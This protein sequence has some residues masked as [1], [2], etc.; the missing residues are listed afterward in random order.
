[1]PRFL[2]ALLAT[3]IAAGAAASESPPLEPIVFESA[4]SPGAASGILGLG[5]S[6]QFWPGH[7]FY[8]DSPVRVSG[9][10]GGITNAESS[11]LT[12]FAALVSLSGPQDFPDAL[13]LDAGDLVATSLVDLPAGISADVTVPLEADLE[14]G[15]YALVFGF[16]AFGA[17]NKPDNPGVSLHSHLVDTQPDQSAFVAVQTFLGGEGLFHRSPP[18]TLIRTFVRGRVVPEA[19]SGVMA[20]LG[21][22]FVCCKRRMPRP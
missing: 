11:S 15:W 9:V 1:M 22:G 16:D 13:D 14:P 4:R 6:D 7:R 20:A 19:A 2:C 5:I 18:T 8:L 3:A 10:G 17:S 12:A 21:V